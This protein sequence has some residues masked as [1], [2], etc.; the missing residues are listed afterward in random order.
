MA[1]SD[2]KMTATG[3][4]RAPKR[5]KQSILGDVKRDAMGEGG[6]SQSQKE[7]MGEE[8]RV[9]GAQQGKTVAEDLAQAGLGSGWSG[10]MAEAARQTTKGSAAAGAMGSADA[11][12]YSEGLARQFAKETKARLEAQQNRS[13][14]NA[15]FWSQQGLNMAKAIPGLGASFKGMGG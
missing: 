5:A 7:A 1:L 3:G 2:Y 13:R 9:A 10:Q 8:A 12:K 14:Q 11:S 15:Q 4:I 6:L